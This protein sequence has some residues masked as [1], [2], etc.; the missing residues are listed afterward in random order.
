[1][2][3]LRMILCGLTVC[4]L[5]A[6]NI[7]RSVAAEIDYIEDFALAPN[8]E[9]VLKQLIP[10]TEDYYYYHC[11]HY[12]NNEQYDKVDDLLNLWIARYKYTNRVQEIRYRQALLTYNRDPQASL[13][14]VRKELGINFNHQREILGRKPDLPTSLDA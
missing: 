10:G 13:E 6:I 12:Q 1:M 5:A 2:L 4:V 7:G 8:R 11:L 14:F 9:E 3:R